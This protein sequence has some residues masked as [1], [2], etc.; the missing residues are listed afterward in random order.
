MKK[1]ILCVLPLTLVTHNAIIASVGS[2]QVFSSSPF[3][4]YLPNLQSKYLE[5]LYL[6]MEPGGH[7][8]KEATVPVSHSKPMNSPW[9]KVYIP[10]EVL[11][12]DQTEDM[13]LLTACTHKHVPI[14]RH[15]LTQSVFSTF[16]LCWVKS[17]MSPSIW[18]KC[19]A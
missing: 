10:A 3:L 2:W 11:I 9:G 1:Y 15:T 7:W 16:H 13:A 8:R 12:K 18:Q 17:D 4:N 14:W 19:Q 6:L 5:C